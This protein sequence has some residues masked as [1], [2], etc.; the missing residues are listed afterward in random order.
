[1]Q[2]AGGVRAGH[3]AVTLR[4]SGNRRAN[5]R[6]VNRMRGDRRAQRRIVAMPMPQPLEVAVCAH[7]HRIR[8]RAELRSMRPLF[9]YGPGF[10]EK[11][12]AAVEKNGD[13]VHD[14]SANNIT[15]PI[16]MD[17]VTIAM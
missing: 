2:A 16:Q 10:E 15:A 4:R 7:V 1:M 6:I 11:H 5:R 14:G 9:T 13:V 12:H 3:D 8:E 17:A